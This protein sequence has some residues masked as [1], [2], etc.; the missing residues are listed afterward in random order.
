MVIWSCL[1]CSVL[2]LFRIQNLWEIVFEAEDREEGRG[3][4]L[5]KAD[6]VIKEIAPN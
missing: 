5:Q 2:H 6:V 4:K 1:K 3:L